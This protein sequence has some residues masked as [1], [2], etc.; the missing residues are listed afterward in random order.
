MKSGE[1]LIITLIVFFVAIGIGI[2]IYFY[3][4]DHHNEYSSDGGY[5]SISLTNK[6]QLHHI[7][8]LP[9][10]RE[11]MLLPEQKVDLSLSYDD[12]LNSKSKNFDQT[13]D[14]YIYRITNPKVS[15]L[16][17]T[18]SGF[19]SNITGTENVTLINAAPY[20]V[21]FVERS[22]R[23]GRRWGK[24]IVPPYSD[25]KGHFVSKNTTWEVNRADQEDSP[26]SELHVAGK[27]STLL[28]DGNVLKSY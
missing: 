3:A 18:S 15:E 26:I 11:I 24:A 19:K 27:P 28:F 16:Y 21:L 9:D 20:S 6:T 5:R 4:K 7:V 1:I 25:S 13:K 23:G 14:H 8:T 2:G 12:V 17:I 10:K 22:S